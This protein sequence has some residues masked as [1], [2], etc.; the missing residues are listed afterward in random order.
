LDGTIYFCLQNALV[1][2]LVVLLMIGE[3]GLMVA[4]FDRDCRGPRFQWM[5]SPPSTA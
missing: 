4:P 3:E 5:G 1:A 2:T